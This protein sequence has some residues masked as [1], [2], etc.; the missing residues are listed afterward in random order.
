MSQ[1]RVPVFRRFLPTER[2]GN[3]EESRRV[4]LD[5]STTAL[6]VRPTPAIRSRAIG[7]SKSFEVT[8]IGGHYGREAAANSRWFSPSMNCI[9]ATSEALIRPRTIA[10]KAYLTSP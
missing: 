4:E 1:S 10:E 9:S 7:G 2:G 5:G 8:S 3:G 6:A